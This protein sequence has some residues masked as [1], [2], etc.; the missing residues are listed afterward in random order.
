MKKLGVLFLSALL[1]LWA[2]NTIAADLSFPQTEEEIIQGLSIKDGSTVYKGIEYV[3]EQGKVYKVIKGKRYR[4]R[5]LAGIAEAGIT[6]RVGA[7]I[8]FDFNKATIK[9]DAHRILDEFGKALSRGLLDAVIQIEGHT[10]LVGSSQA[11]QQLSL[12]RAKAIKDYLITRH[13]VDPGRLAVVGYGETRP[14]VN[15]EGESEQ[16]RR[17]EFLRIQ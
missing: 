9:P 1:V 4:V 17:V 14:L 2:G 10:D 8:R 16:N 15:I 13:G 11:N 5:G 6:P 12:K 3:A 7:L